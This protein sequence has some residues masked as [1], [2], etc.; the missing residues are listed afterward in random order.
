MILKAQNKL[1]STIILRLDE[2][3]WQ[4]DDAAKMDRKFREAL[5][6]SLDERGMLWPPIVWT[7]ET[8]L[9]YYNENPRRQDPTK[10]VDIDY[11]WRCAIGNNRLEYAK[12]SGYTS[13]ECV[14]AERWQDKDRILSVTQMEYRRDF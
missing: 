11:H 3:F 7:Q 6:K 4:L 13:I 2:I 8:F 14:I 5:K 12:L 1:E 10:P 9:Q